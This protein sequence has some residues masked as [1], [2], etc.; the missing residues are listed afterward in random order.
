M[1]AVFS[2]K[3]EFEIDGHDFI[4][5]AR[6]L[7]KLELIEISKKMTSFAESD[8]KVTS[9]EVLGIFCEAIDKILGAGAFDKIYSDYE[10]TPESCRDLLM[11]LTDE[12]KK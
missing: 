12:M 11:F 3:K 4:V 8:S 6:S 5:D 2:F 9:E 7:K 1:K 10:A